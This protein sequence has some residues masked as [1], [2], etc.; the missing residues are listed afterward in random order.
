MIE[1]PWRVKLVNSIIHSAVE[2]LTMMFE[3]P[4][5]VASRALRARAPVLYVAQIFI[6]DLRVKFKK[7]GTSIKIRLIHKRNKK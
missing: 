6:L 5:G 3:T 4:M 7:F 2:N 1:V